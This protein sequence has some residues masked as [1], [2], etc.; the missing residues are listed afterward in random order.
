MFLSDDF[1]VRIYKFLNEPRMEVTEREWETDWSS[2]DGN[3]DDDDDGDDDD[4]M[5]MMMTMV[6]NV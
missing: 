2:D 4:D 5:M 3:D 6:R 1:L